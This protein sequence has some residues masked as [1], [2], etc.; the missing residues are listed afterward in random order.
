[1]K[2]FND[3]SNA[4]GDLIR[5]YREDKHFSRADLSRELD[6]RGFPI[7]PD[8]LYRIERQKMVLKD[9]ELIAICEV[10]DIDYKELKRIINKKR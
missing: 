6:L 4:Y 1:M 3:K 2:K 5:K 9:F 7:S 8:E 10:L